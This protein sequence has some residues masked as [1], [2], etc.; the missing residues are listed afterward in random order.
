[1]P[2]LDNL[3]SLIAPHACLQCGREGDLVCGW[4]RLE[5]FVPVPSRCYRCKR[6]SDNSATCLSCR[7]RAPLRHVWIA[8]GYGGIAKDLLHAFKFERARAALQIIGSVSTE[9]LPYMPRDTLVIPIPTATNRVR[10]RGY[11]QAVLLA[12]YIARQT[13]LSYAQPLVRLTKS[14]QVGADRRHRL[15]QLE[16]AFYLPN[17]E[18]TQKQDILLV[19][20]VITTG[21]TLE[22]VARLLKQSGAK[23]VSALLF[24]QKQ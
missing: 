21:A 16:R 13:G 22:T 19:D 17:P 9:A 8:T 14:R 18:K 12:R 11:D 4:C 5:A 2:L 15:T 24:A 10:Q 7:R 1:M 20:D 23:S 6:L 3:L